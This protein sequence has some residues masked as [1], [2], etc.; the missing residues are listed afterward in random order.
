MILNI[1]KAFYN[2]NDSFNTKFSTYAQNEFGRAD[3]ERLADYLYSKCKAKWQMIIKYT[4][5]IYS[6]YDRPGLYIAK[7][8]KKYQVSFMN[9]NDKDC[10]HLIITNYKVL[11]D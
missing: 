2:Y 4:P 5:F 8:D 10:E 1:I 11:K 7:F 6:L 9:R 3:Q